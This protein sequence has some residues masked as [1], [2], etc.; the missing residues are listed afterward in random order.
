MTL[1]AEPCREQS[2]HIRPKGGLEYARGRAPRAVFGRGGFP[3]FFTFSPGACRYLLVLDTL[4]T[5]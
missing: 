3:T 2:E 4:F 5:L 1:G